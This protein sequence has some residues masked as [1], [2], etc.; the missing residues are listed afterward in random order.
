MW[1]KI[2]HAFAVNATQATEPTPQQLELVDRLCGVIK[3]RRLTPAAVA[4]LEMVRPMNYVG[5]Q[6]MHFLEPIATTIFSPTQYR[7]L[8]LF[9]ERRDAVDIIC[10]RLEALESGKDGEDILA[11]GDELPN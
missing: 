11:S 6:G 7:E 2:K 4:F 9:L 5:A 10:E 1:E 3:Q 8:S